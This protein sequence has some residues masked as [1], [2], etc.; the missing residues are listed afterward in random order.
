MHWLHF[1]LLNVLQAFNHFSSLFIAFWICEGGSQGHC[2]LRVFVC[3]YPG[4]HMHTKHSIG[5]VLISC[6]WLNI[7]GQYPN[8]SLGI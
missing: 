6:Y 2:S 8:C 7:L 4:R 5:F 3:H 1:L